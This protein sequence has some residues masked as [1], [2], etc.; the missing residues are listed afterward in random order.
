MD[1]DYVIG[2]AISFL[3]SVVKVSYATAQLTSTRAKNFKHLGLFYSCAQGRFLEGKSHPIRYLVYLIYMLLI[4]PLFSWL[5]VASAAGAFIWDM[6]RRQPTPEKIKDVH[7]KLGFSVLP[8]EQVIQL[9]RDLG[10]LVGEVNLIR[11]VRESPYGTA[12]LQLDKVRKLLFINS[13]TADYQTDH[14]LELEFRISATHVDYRTISDS[15]E[16]AGG[17][18]E[19]DVI[20]NVVQESQIRKRREGMSDHPL[21]NAETTIAHL[22]K[23]VE[24][25]PIAEPRFISYFVL[26]NAN[27][28]SLFD[29]RKFFQSE[30]QRIETGCREIL[31]DVDTQG[32]IVSETED[33]YDITHRDNNDKAAREKLSRLFDEESWHNRQ[34]VKN[35]FFGKKTALAEI[36][37]WLERTK[38]AA[39]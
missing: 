12:T 17:E 18:V 35:E 32:G 37:G 34:I 8:K 20:D 2:V 7:Y 10:N 11:E 38:A 13:R 6:S 14:R 25:H 3:V 5:A 4:A 39:A 21:F 27:E 24:W 23:S 22:K 1:F 33:G 29:L 36:D 31:R 28:L 15:T 9:A 16:H 26:V 30:K 19:N